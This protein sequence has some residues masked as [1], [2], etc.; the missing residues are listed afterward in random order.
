MPRLEIRG[1]QEKEYIINTRL[2]TI[3]LTHYE[4]YPARGNADKHTGTDS[5]SIG[6]LCR[7]PGNYSPRMGSY[8]KAET[9]PNLNPH[10]RNLIGRKHR[11]KRTQAGQFL[12]P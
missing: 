8:K 1:Q 3:P 2:S 11:G 5:N 9:T 7:V 4:L 12:N 6:E 10:P